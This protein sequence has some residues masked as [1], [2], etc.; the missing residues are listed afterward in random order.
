MIFFNE[1]INYTMNNIKQQSNVFFFFLQDMSVFKIFMNHWMIEENKAKKVLW[2]KEK[3]KK[4][5]FFI[6]TR[7]Y[8]MRFMML[9][10]QMGDEE[11]PMSTQ[12]K[13]YAF[14]LGRSSAVQGCCLS[15]LRSVQR[16]SLLER[17]GET[18]LIISC[19]DKECQSPY[20]I[21]NLTE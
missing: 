20:M 13:K 9:Y 7:L 18:F 6:C 8:V 2:F 17:Y 16:F 11:Y 4:M 19:Q 3:T 5:H 12:L 10:Q 1:P 15:C 21:L 14:F